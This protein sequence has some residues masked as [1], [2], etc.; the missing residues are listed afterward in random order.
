MSQSV[1]V[2]SDEDN[3]G[4]VIQPVQKGNQLTY[5]KNGESVHIVAMEDIPIY[6]KVALVDILLNQPIIKYGEHIGLAGCLI[7]QGEH[8]H[9][10]NVVS[11][12]ENL[13]E[14]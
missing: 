2:I 9:I 6:H 4:V 5:L 1:M 12:R 11:H 13:R 10:H 3:V 7:R 14:G 8:V